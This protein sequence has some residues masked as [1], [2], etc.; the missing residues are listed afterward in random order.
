[1]MMLHILKGN[2]SSN[3]KIQFRT[4]ELKKP[5]KKSFNRDKSRP[6]HMISLQLQWLT[7]KKQNSIR[8]SKTTKM[9]ISILKMIQRTI[10]KMKSIKRHRLSL[11]AARKTINQ[12][13]LLPKSKTWLQSNQM[14]SSVASKIK[15]IHWRSSIVVTMMTRRRIPCLVTMLLLIRT[16]HYSE[17]TPA[18]PTL[19]AT[20]RLTTIRLVLNSR[21]ELLIIGM[22]W[23]QRVT[24][25]ISLITT[26]TRTHRRNNSQLEAAVSYLQACSIEETWVINDK[27]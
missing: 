21:W 15:P 5:R 3:L 1:M 2:S 9:T 6:K 8:I 24:H 16:P 11:I 23:C 20:T 22:T 25:I 10:N 18:R 26:T 27:M 14:Q 19:S 17:I 13:H 12:T 4:K 7:K